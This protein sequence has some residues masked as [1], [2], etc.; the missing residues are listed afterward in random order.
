MMV[1]VAAEK[2]ARAAGP[3]LSDDKCLSL[4][5]NGQ[6]LT[7]QRLRPGHLGHSRYYS[8]C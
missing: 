7:C 1:E 3:G 4:A 5:A 8:L 2:K 6:Q